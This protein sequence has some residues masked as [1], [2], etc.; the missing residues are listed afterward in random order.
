MSRTREPEACGTCG[1]LVA[2]RRRHRQWHED[3]G[4]VPAPRPVRYVGDPDPDG[5]DEQGDAPG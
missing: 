4:T 5:H 3:T 1:V 2:D